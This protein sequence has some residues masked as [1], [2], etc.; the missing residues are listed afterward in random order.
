MTFGM[1][2]QLLFGDWIGLQLATGVPVL[3]TIEGKE[4]VRVRARNQDGFVLPHQ[5]QP[6]RILEVNFIDVGQGDGCHIVTPDDK[7]FLVDAGPAD[8]MY[9]FLRW[10]FNLK[11]T[12]IDPPPFTAVISHS[13]ADHY[14]GFGTIFTR[15]TD[16]SRQFSIDRV[17]HNGMIEM[18]GTDEDTLGTLVADN[19]TAYITDLCDDDAAYQ[20]RA[21]GPGQAGNYIALLQKTTAPKQAL[22]QGSAPIYNA[23]NLT[24]EVVGPVA[25]LI[26]G[27]AALPVLG[28]SGKKGKTKNGH[29]II[30]KLTFGKVRILLGGD[31]N[32]P[33][34]DYLMRHY[35]GTDVT[36]IRKKLKSNTTTSNE[37]AVLQQQLTQAIDE[38]RKVFEVEVAKS[39]HH[40]SADFTSEFLR[41]INPLVTVISS[42][43]DEPHVHPRPDTLGTIGKHSRGERSLIFSTELARSGKEFIDVT[44]LLP[45]I[46]KERVVTVYG[47][48]NVR[49]DGE[50][51]IIAQ[52]LERRAA[53]GD[54]DIHKL[55]WNP[56]TSEFE[57]Q[58]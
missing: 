15:I 17:Y 44:K 56:T 25:Q 27:K 14:A 7:H 8:N 4:Y 26:G 36:M 48:I 29:S 47:M 52:K 49:T 13:D 45:G 19:G 12:S 50:Q 46:S 5:I 9:R 30:L 16:G 10:R 51:I 2:K 43:D 39:C 32:E 40:G 11:Q 41:A 34:E 42:G 38:A 6:K 54:W 33:A 1:V 18:S 22:R 31:L 57:Y 55:A 53:R 58:P 21:S 37:K 24:I 20:A 28:S 3:E 35:T 23:A